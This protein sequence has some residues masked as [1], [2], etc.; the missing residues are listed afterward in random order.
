MEAFD[1][2]ADSIVKK[3][4]K[5]KG[6]DE[7]EVQLSNTVDVKDD[8]PVD[9]AVKAKAALDKKLLEKNKDSEDDEKVGTGIPTPEPSEKMMA[10]IAAKKTASAA[11]KATAKDLAKATKKA[12]EVALKVAEMANLDSSQKQ[13]DASKAEILAAKNDRK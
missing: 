13:M 5:D 6:E 8:A 4:N 7:E 10:K 9:P 11:K 12:A 2:E 3:E 1:D